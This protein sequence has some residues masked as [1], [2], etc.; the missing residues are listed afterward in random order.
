MTEIPRPEV[1]VTQR[2]VADRL[3]PSP[4]TLAKWPADEARP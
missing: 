3:G 2:R 4:E 1:L